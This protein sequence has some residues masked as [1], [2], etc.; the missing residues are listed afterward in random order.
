MKISILTA[1]YNRAK[2]L[3]VLYKSIVNN[4]SSKYE[5]EWLIMDDGSVD[6]TED[7]CNKLVGTD[8]SVTSLFGE[9][10]LQI[11]YFKQEN[12]GKMAAINN[13]SEHVTGDLWIECDSDDFFVEN[14]FSK[15]VDEYEKISDRNDIYALAFLKQDLDGNNMGNNFKNEISTM[16][17]LYFK[18]QEDGEKALVFVTNIRKNYRYE[19][20]HNERFVTEAR[21][22]HKMDKDYKMI[23]NNEYMMVCEYQEEGYTKNINKEFVNN[24]FG[25][26]MYF[27]EILNDMDM[28]GVSFGKRLYV[29]KHFILFGYLTGQ[30]GKN[31]STF[32]NNILIAILWIPGK[33][34]SKKYVKSVIIKS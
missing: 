18:E 11:K 19:L 16:Y 31:V 17:D 7:V 3:N 33:M 29:I 13:L 10:R 25:Y 27:Y 4:I 23:C 34:Q 24:P 28:K 6:D 2:Y 12:Q 9:S 21:M 8:K 5:V 22:Y 20:E 30:K 15:I 1:T 26:Y 14:C 32:F